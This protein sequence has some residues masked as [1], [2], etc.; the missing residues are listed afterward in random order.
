M[1]AKHQQS[2]GFIVFS[3]GFRIFFLA[4]AVYGVVSMLLWL[5]WL[6]VHA[7]GGAFT[8]LPFAPPPHHWHAHEMVFGYGTAVL[9]GFFL[10][11]VPNWTGA[12]PSRAAFIATLAAMWLAGRLA[13]FFSGSLPATLVMAVDL[14]FIPALAWKVL[15]N[16]LKRP[17]TQ[18]MMFVGLLALMLAGNLA[19]H[20]DWTGVTSGTADTGLIAG[21]LT[22]AAM[23]AVLGGRVT[24]AFTRNALQRAGGDIALPLSRLP[25][26]IAG[27]AT[28]IALP[29]LVLVDTDARLLAAV[30]GVAA[31]A[32]AVRLAGWRGLSVLRQPILWS[33]HLGF[34]MLVLGYGALALHWAGVDIGR[35]AAVHLVGI[36]AIG[37]MTLAVMSRAALGHTG[38]PLIVP[39][40]VPIAYGF[41]A[42][43]ALVRSAGVILVPEH[44]YSV[45]FVSGGLWVLAFAIFVAVYT[46]IVASPRVE[47]PPAASA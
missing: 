3:E 36:G 17:K 30:D 42:I 46:P 26:E 20:L 11:A 43:A 41:V 25:F 47:A 21:L 10:T 14:V 7:A 24:P 34:L 8:S 33:L 39:A 31:I 16:L 15:S 6:A 38:R 22:L 40:P 35:A 1:T 28:A 32:H 5:G 37:G 45:M 4:A 44:Y 23:I 2:G 9:A 29:L 19:V 13:I 12:L 18:N 27:V